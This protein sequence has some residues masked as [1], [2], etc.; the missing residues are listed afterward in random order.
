MDFDHATYA[1]ATA[2]LAEFA[3]RV[4]NGEGD[5]VAALFVDDAKLE[6]PAFKLDGRKAIDEWFTQRAPKNSPRISRHHSTNIRV[7]PLGGDR[8]EVLANALTLVAQAP[9]PAQGAAVAVGTSRDV[10]RRTPEG[11]RF[12]SRSLGVV[13][14]GRVGAPEPAK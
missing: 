9:A 1:E 5:T 4:D 7:I 8:F 12:E 11:L 6:T 14:E 13:I 3:W 2:L 10:M